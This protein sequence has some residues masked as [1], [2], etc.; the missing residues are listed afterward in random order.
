MN[1]FC[2]YLLIKLT[3]IPRIWPIAN[4]ETC[5][6][7][8]QLKNYA[9]SWYYILWLCYSGLMML[10]LM[11]KTGSYPDAKTRHLRMKIRVL[12]LSLTESTEAVSLLTSSERRTL[13]WI[14]RTALSP[15]TTIWII[16]N[17]DRAGCRRLSQ[18]ITKLVFWNC[19]GIWHIIL[20][21]EISFHSLVPQGM[22]RDLVIRHT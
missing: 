18:T 3:Y 11:S 13:R 9:T 22:K 15:T 7:N 21:N 12:K 5:R 19:W 2:V 14:G 10:W 17:S 8:K 16:T 4:T 1:I 20:I 6:N